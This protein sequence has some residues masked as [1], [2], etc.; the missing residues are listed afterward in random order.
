MLAKQYD[1]TTDDSEGADEEA[2]GEYKE[3]KWGPTM[4]TDLIEL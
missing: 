1:S 4:V 3:Q 2:A